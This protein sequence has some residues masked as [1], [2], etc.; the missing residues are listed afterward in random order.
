MS[1][2]IVDLNFGKYK[3][4]VF[5]YSFQRSRSDP[6]HHPHDD[7]QPFPRIFVTDSFEHLYLLC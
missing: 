4:D 6:L 7:F 1:I 2:K 3:E 5:T